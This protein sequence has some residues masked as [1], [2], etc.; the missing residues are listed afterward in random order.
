MQDGTPKT[1]LPDVNVHEQALIPDPEGQLIIG[2]PLPQEIF[3][4]TGLNP[5]DGDIF[6]GINAE[7]DAVLE[8]DRGDGHISQQMIVIDGLR[9]AFALLGEEPHAPHRN[10]ADRAENTDNKPNPIEATATPIVYEKGADMPLVDLQR[11]L[12][13]RIERVAI[14]EN[15][16][17]TP[18]LALPRLSAISTKRSMFVSIKSAA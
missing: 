16:L 10:E 18:G 15:I 2:S 9:Q 12:Q 1:E 6:V 5:E 8:H 3:E 14:A 11:E 7:G 4:I 17:R 13:G